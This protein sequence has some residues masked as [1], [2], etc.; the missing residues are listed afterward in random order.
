ME[1]AVVSMEDCCKLNGAGSWGVSGTGH[2]SKCQ[3]ASGGEASVIIQENELPFRTCLNFG[4]SFYR[5]F[6][7]LEY[8]FSGACTYTLATDFNNWNI[9][10]TPVH[11]DYWT[12]CRKRVKISIKNGDVV[13]TEGG[14][15]RINDLVTNLTV[16]KPLETPNKCMF[17]S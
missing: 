5:M 7:G 8:Q 6:D 14:I 4:R 10:V 9:E 12:T 15:I 13:E 11:C 17:F 3:S 16:D 1:G 2:C